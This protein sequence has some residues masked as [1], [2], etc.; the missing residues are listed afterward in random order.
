MSLDQ[1][2]N[3]ILLST[4]Y[5]TWTTFRFLLNSYLVNL[6]IPGRV[7]KIV[8]S[9][10]IPTPSPVRN[11]LPLWRTIM[12]PAFASRPGNNLIPRRRPAES[13]P[14]VDDPAAFLVAMVLVVWKDCRKGWWAINRNVDPAA[15]I[16]NRRRSNAMNWMGQLFI[17]L[18][19]SLLP[20][21]D[22]I[23]IWLN[24]WIPFEVVLS[25]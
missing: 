2:Q 15:D 10:P 25:S 9:R 7:A 19:F 14:F 24:S 6:T 5:I 11:F 20:V 18:H 12:A 17:P 4:A 21:D 22:V 3:N 8:W 16:S 1:T 23:S 13:R